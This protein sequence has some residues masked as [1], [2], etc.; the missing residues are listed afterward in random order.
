MATGLPVVVSTGT[1]VW[2]PGDLVEDGRQ[3]H[4]Y[5][6]G[7]QEGLETAMSLLLDPRRRQAAGQAA[8]ERI[9]SWDYGTAVKSWVDALLTIARSSPGK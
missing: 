8:L 1:G 9:Q 3:G 6:A 5:E 4:V 7:D 2:G